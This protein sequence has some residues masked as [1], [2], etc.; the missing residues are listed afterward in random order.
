[1]LAEDTAVAAH[2]ERAA[3]ERLTNPARYLGEAL[4]VVDRVLARVEATSGVSAG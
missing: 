2:F 3:L 1:V 4:A